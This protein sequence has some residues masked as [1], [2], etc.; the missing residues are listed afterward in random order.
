ML[1]NVIRQLREKAG[2]TQSEMARFLEIDRTTYTK[3][4]SGKSRPDTNMLQKIAE[5]FEVSTDYLLGRSNEK[6]VKYETKAYHNI[7][8]EGLPDEAIKQVE[9]YIE[10]IKL[11]YNPDGTLKKK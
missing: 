5:K 6:E 1:S 4:E 9:D 2:L 7:S 8:V 10:L 11:K 3:Y